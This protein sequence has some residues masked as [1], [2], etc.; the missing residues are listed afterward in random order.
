MFFFKYK[1]VK[2]ST[3]YYLFIFIIFL[4]DIISFF[5]YFDDF[6]WGYSLAAFSFITYIILLSDCWGQFKL[7]RFNVIAF[8]YTLILVLN[9][10][11]MIFQLKVL[12]SSMDTNNLLFAGQVIYHVTL[13]STVGISVAYY[14]NS[15]SHKS[16]LFL[17]GSLLF[18][19]ADILAGAHYF[20]GI[21]NFILAFSSLMAASGYF[22]FFNYFH[23]KEE[24]LLTE[25]EIIA[26]IEGKKKTKRPV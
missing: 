9:A 19:C 5:A 13:L 20:Y 26:D 6:D 4:S 7:G 8:S 22:F 1:P 21:G 3:R 12:Y 15:Y 23:V 14:L 2:I 18:I 11:L 25:A 10:V 17:M 24:S 16:M